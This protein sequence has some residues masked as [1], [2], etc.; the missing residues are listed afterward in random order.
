M[1][2]C[3]FQGLDSSHLLQTHITG[4]MIHGRRTLMLTD[5]IQWPHDSNLTI[6]AVLYAITSEFPEGKLPPFL[7]IQMDNCSRE[8]KNKF[9]IGI[10]ALIVKYKVVKEVTLSFL[11][12][13]HTHEGKFLSAMCITVFQF[14]FSVKYIHCL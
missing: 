3:N 4:V 7:D 12:V 9:F 2:S 14:C 6:N 8:N 13:G 11:M 1:L 5:Y 10:M